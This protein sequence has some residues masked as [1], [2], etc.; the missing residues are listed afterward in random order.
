MTEKEK[1]C[2]WWFDSRGWPKL[3]RYQ[4]QRRDQDWRQHWHQ[5][6][7]QL[8]PLV[9][10]GVSSLPEVSSS[11]F[12]GFTTLKCR[13]CAGNG[14]VTRVHLF[15]YRSVVTLARK[16][17]WFSPERAGHNPSI[18]S[19]LSLTCSHTSDA[20]EKITIR[21]EEIVELSKQFSQS[22]PSRMYVWVNL[23]VSHKNSFNVVIC[24]SDSDF[25]TW[26][27]PDFELTPYTYVTVRWIS[28]C[29]A[30]TMGLS[31]K[32]S[33]REESTTN[34]QRYQTLT[35]IRT[36]NHNHNPKHN[37]NSYTIPNTNTNINHW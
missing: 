5:S 25:E 15:E 10:G 9:A 37:N 16:E 13:V 27:W 20:E 35:P 3:S 29:D 33:Q 12:L 26:N 18:L 22:E 31:Q 2:K 24:G 21:D 23:T 36:H 34:F 19:E 1:Q 6:R 30:E 14:V 8:C 7:H 32:L 11:K 17:W 4:D 28:T